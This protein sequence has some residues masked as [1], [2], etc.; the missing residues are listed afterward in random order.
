MHTTIDQ[1][2]AKI[3]KKHPV[4][5]SI[6]ANEST[7]C[8]LG[9]TIY[10]FVELE[11]EKLMYATD[12]AGRARIV[13]RESLTPTFKSVRLQPIDHVIQITGDGPYKGHYYAGGEYDGYI[14]TTTD[15]TKAHKMC[16][17]T[18]SEEAKYWAFHAQYCY[19]RNFVA[20]SVKYPL[21]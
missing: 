4:N 7:H 1:V 12:K 19:G 6:T 20:I 10:V 3:S 21:S 16:H 18:A 11:D 17:Y 2:L 14:K 5:Y 15:I 9:H 8:V 13:H